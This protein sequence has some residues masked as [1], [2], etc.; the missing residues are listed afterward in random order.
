MN[1]S[2]VTSQHITNASGTVAIASTSTSLGVTKVVNSAPYAENSGIIDTANAVI[3][4]AD[5]IGIFS[6]VVLLASFAWNVYATR[7]RLK[8][9]AEK[10]EFD[11]RY[12]ELRQR[13]HELELAKFKHGICNNENQ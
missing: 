13:E 9:K 4:T 3:T 8:F 11:Q 1:L 2:A 7:K 6:A 5:M 10:A 12:L